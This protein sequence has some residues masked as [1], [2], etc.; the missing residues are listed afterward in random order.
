MSALAS[1]SE[2]FSSKRFRQTPLSSLEPIMLRFIDLCVLLRKTRNVKEGLHMYK[3]VAQNTSVSSVEMVVQHFITK[4]KEKLDEALAKVDEIEGPLVAEGADQENGA[5][6]VDDLEA[7]E[8]PESLLMSTVSEEKSRDRT[9]R[10]LVTPWL[11]SL[12]E[13][14]RTALDI[15]RNNSRLENFY[16]VGQYNPP[17]LL[18]SLSLH[19]LHSLITPFI[20]SSKSPP[21][22]S[23]SVSPTPARPSL[24]DWQK[25][26]DRT[27]HHPKN[28]PTRP[29]PSTCP[30]L[31]CFSV[32]SRLASS[33]STH[34]S[35]LSY[36]RNPSAP[37]KIS[38]GSS[39]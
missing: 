5:A 29:T 8:T 14:Y 28:T 39:V 10:E 25:L 23:S 21:R 16:Q 7:T 31:M 27:S 34:L 35:S 19:S 33:S 38:T 20:L 11:R 18:A 22:P 1:I 36:G 30:I 9:Y 32:I 15:L 6:L 13:A 4:S 17:P 37:L 12:W 26:C 2:I 3:N 24:E